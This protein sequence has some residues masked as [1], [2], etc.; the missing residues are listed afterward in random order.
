M[1][2]VR[3]VWTTGPGP[4]ESPTIATD[5]AIAFLNSRWRNTLEAHDLS[6][7][8]TRTLLTHTPYLWGPSVSPDGRQVAFSRGE[9]DGTWHIWSVPFD[10][11]SARQLAATDAG[12]VYP[13]WGPDGTYVLFNSWSAPRRIGRVPAEGGAATMLTFAGDAAASFADIAPGGTRIAFSRPEPQGERIYVASIRGGATNL[14]TPSPGAI[15]RWSP[16]GSLIAFASDRGYSGGIVVIHA[17]G[18]G[19][20]RLTT[21]G[22]WPVWW[23]DGRQLGYLAIGPD[24]NQ[25]IRLVELDGSASPRTLSIKLNGTN[26]PFAVTPDGRSIVVSN[27]LHVS[28]EIWLVEPKR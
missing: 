1:A 11:G 19:E 28:D 27:A 17:D 15:P 22:G 5:G 9:V 6:N 16:D 21:D 23:P 2:A 13:R 8:S 14:L 20:R 18:S 3:F 7:Q 4:D 12:E 10:G 26:H 25:Q 24:G